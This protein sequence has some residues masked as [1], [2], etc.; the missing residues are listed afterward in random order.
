VNFSSAAAIN[1]GQ[2]IKITSSGA[3]SNVTPTMAYVVIEGLIVFA[4]F[5]ASRCSVSRKRGGGRYDQLRSR[6]YRNTRQ[7]W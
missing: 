7:Q 1:E 4:P 2:S 5:A 6:P 3:G